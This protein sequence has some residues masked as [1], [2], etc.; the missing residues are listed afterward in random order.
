MPLSQ[1]LRERHR[2][3]WERMVTHPFVRE[4]GTGTLPQEKFQG[5]FLQDY[6]FLRD[7]VTLLA[8]GVAK[9]PSMDV[10][11]R[12]ATF[13]AGVLQGEESLFREA[14]R[15]WG[16]APER[17]THPEPGP[18]A[19]AMGDMMARIAYGGGFPEILSVLV[20][21]EWTYLDWAT[22]LSR[23]GMPADP[24]QRRW[25][26]IHCNADFRAFVQWLIAPL[27]SL[28]LTDEQRGR[29]GRLFLAT[30]R[31]EVAFWEA[32]YRGEA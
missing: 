17:Y 27:D 11:R 2:D 26:E 18:T 22:R 14:F 29:V 1:Q 6:V 7:F 3:L 32:A 13:M 10:A 25:V 9:A 28:A 8:L 5:Y 20:V 23:S 31:Y 4:M 30:L 12:L 24:V 21:T 16:L 19:K 15:D